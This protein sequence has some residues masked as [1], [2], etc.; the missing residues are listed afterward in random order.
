[1]DG[2]YKSGATCTICPYSCKTCIGNSI[3]SC[4]SCPIGYTLSSATVG[5]CN[6]DTTTLTRE[7]WISNGTLANNNGTFTPT[8]SP[9]IG[10]NTASCGNITW[11]FGY[12]S[13]IVS[14]MTLNFP[15]VKLTYTS[16]SYSNGAHYGLHFRATFLFID[17]WKSTA[18][19]IFR[20]G[21]RDIYSYNYG[22]ETLKGEYLCGQNY[23]D[24]IAII[25]F[26]FSHTSTNVNL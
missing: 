24:H 9:S 13:Y 17:Q 8:I 21:S 19:I 4:T 7:D 10:S 6:K 1:M 3:T 12:S 11:V 2:Y 5:S 16:S 26:Y 22:M 14:T 20:E 23:H 15:S 25:D 18:S